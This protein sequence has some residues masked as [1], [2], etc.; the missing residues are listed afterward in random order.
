VHADQA[1][2]T[3]ASADD[4]PAFVTAIDAAALGG[5]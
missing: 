5:S 2:V 3:A 4:L 1:I